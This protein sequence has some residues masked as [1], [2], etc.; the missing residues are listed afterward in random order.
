MRFTI[1]SLSLLATAGLWARTNPAKVTFDY[2][3]K[4]AVVRAASPFKPAPD[5]LPQRLRDLTY[6]ERKNIKFRPDRALWRAEKCPFQIEFF[7]RGGL[8][9]ERVTLHEFGP[10]RNRVIAFDP[11]FF[12]YGSI[13]DL[14]ELSPDI[15]YAGVRLLYPLNQSE[16]VNEFLTFLG[17]SY[18]RAVGVGQ[19]YGLSARGI[20]IDAAI[21]GKEEEFPRFTDFWLGMPGPGARTIT[22]YAL[23]DGPSVTGVYEFEITP[24]QATVVDVRTKLFFRTGGKFAGFAPLTSMFWY[25][26]NMDRPSGELRPEVHDS[27]G[28]SVKD[29]GAPR[30]WKPLHNPKAAEVTTIS[31]KKLERFGLMQRD[32][33]MA[34]YEDLE[35]RYALR[36]S[37]WIEPHESW[38]AGAIQLRELPATKEY[39][40]NVVVCWVPEQKPEPGR[41][42]EM[43][44]R[45]VW[46]MTE[47][48]DSAARVVATR[49]GP[50]PQV[51]RGRRF[52]ID[53]ADSKK[54][55]RNEA[56]LDADIEVGEGGRVRHHALAAYPEVGGWRL[57]VDVDAERAGDPVALRC[58]LREGREQISET[59]WYSW[60]P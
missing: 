51:E 8:F 32:R 26:E 36:P 11:E 60:R 38:T 9:R 23:L 20:A 41:P 21:P 6:D 13:K 39:A 27:D 33:H 48:D 30:I 35:A 12:D 49:E 53:F 29:S 10:E 5:D 40:D 37:A 28:L 59:W 46:S 18:F 57:A 4:I 7:P 50:L 14:G 44:Y 24:G 55:S 56:T 34:N 43:R 15:G 25:G 22:L 54:S 3:E 31:V 52:W 42:A 17:A 47:A 2:V 1:V 58:H 16:N 19:Q 45:I